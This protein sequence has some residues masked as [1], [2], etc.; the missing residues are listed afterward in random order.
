MALHH[1]GGPTRRHHPVQSFTP[2]N[3]FAGGIQGAWFDPSDIST[4]FQDS[5]GTTPVTAVEQPVGKVLDKSGRGNHA[6]QATAGNR[7]TYRARYNQLLATATL[8]TQSITTLAATY[9]IS[10][11]G[12]GT[13]TLS[14][15]GS[16]V[17]SAG[18]NTFVATAG[19]LTCTVAGA[20]NNAD[21]RLNSTSASMPAYQN[22]VTGTNYD[23]AGFLPYLAFNGTSSSMA[24]ASI[25]FT[26]AQMSVFAGVTKLSDAASAIAAE[27]SATVSSNAGA[28]AFFAPLTGGVNSYSFFAGGTSLVSASIANQFPAPA[29][30]VATMLGDISAPSLIHR[31]NG[32]QLQ[33]T[34]TSQGTGT[35]GNYPLYI[36]ARAG[37]SLFF[38]GN[39]YGLVVRG[40]SSTAAEIAA[41]E[42]WMNSKAQA[43]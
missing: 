24:T 23:A 22:V 14:G 42:A 31:E 33:N 29:T 28:F 18:T 8:S 5:A 39:L 35:Y 7:P 34:V 27:L 2:L 25:P 6:T 21:I 12:A 40:A 38:N 15:T 9:R 10:F 11:S 3:L 19:T 13:V 30:N 41:T 20:V 16:G 26:L 32:T 43:Y 17:F 36:G 1:L 37:T 4:L